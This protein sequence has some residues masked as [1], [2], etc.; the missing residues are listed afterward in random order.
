MKL[1]CR[2]ASGYL[3]HSMSQIYIHIRLRKQ[4]LEVMRTRS[5]VA[6]ADADCREAAD[7]VHTGQASGKEDQKKRIL[8]VSGQVEES[9][10]GRCQLGN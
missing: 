6:E 1:N 7:G 8:R 3:R 5:P 10:S 9:P 4:E 2:M